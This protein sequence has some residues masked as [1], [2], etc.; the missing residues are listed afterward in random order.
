MVMT[1][2]TIPSTAPPSLL[3]NIAHRGARSLA[4]ENT[5]AA[6]DKAWRVGA[7]GV[8]VDVSVTADGELILFHD[9][10][11]PKRTEQ[12]VTAFTWEELQRLDAG[13]WF[14]ESDPL[15]EIG[16]GNV[17]PSE[18]SAIGGVQIPLLED[19]LIYVKS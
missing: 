17:T 10:L 14:L 9:D 6:I 16:E 11:F 7:H 15:G 3:Y 4:P 18:Q 13:S 2:T 19:V 5:M 8:E 1:V 12:P